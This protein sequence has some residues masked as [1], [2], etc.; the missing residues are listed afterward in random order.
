MCLHRGIERYEGFARLVAPVPEDE[1]ALARLQVDQQEGQV[2]GDCGVDAAYVA[3]VDG[4]DVRVPRQ[5]A[6]G[7]RKSTNKETRILC[8]KIYGE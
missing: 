6:P 8:G 4:D 5:V 2:L 1:L 3:A 7:M